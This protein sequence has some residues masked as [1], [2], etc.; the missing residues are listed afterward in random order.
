MA[1]LGLRVCIHESSYR[2]LTDHAKLCPA[3]V[4]VARGIRRFRFLRLEHSIAIFSA[5]HGDH[6]PDR[7]WEMLN[8]FASEGM[9]ITIGNYESF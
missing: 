2:T 3:Y 7:G 8:G 6:K 9:G 4:V 5:A 1:V